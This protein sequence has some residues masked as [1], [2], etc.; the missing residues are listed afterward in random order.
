VA[1]SQP[2]TTAASPNPPAGVPLASP[3]A[4]PAA[5]ATSTPE[6]AS[7]TV[8]VGTTDGGG[9]YLRE[10]THVG[11]RSA[12]LPK[13]TALVLRAKEPLEG[14]GVLWYSVHALDGEEGYVE[15][16]FTATT[17][18]TTAPSGPRGQPN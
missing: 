17:Q 3:S 12:V 9:V 13:G 14:D 11:D 6:A 7:Q 2:A 10:S 16:E 18:P 15:V 5:P 8:W 4:S 1:T